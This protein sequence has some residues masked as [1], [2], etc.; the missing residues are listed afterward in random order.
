MMNLTYT[1]CHDKLYPLAPKDIT[2]NNNIDFEEK[3]EIEDFT[4]DNSLTLTDLEEE[5]S[6]NLI[7]AIIERT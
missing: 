7:N 5:Q 3:S 1:N 4:S 2:F 6:S